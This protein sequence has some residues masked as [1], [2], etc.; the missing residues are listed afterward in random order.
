M[1]K[2]A[3]RAAEIMTRIR[4]LFEKNEMKREV[5]NVNEV[6][7]DTVSLIRAEANRRSIRVETELDAQL[8]TISADR[9]QLQQVLINLMLNGLEA[10]NDTGGELV[11]KSQRN[12]GGAPQISVSD[13]GRGLPG[14]EREKIFD[15]FYTTKQQGTGM[16]LA[17]SRSIV[18]SHGGRLWASA[19]SGR[20]ATFYVSL[21][22]AVTET[23]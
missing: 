12:D 17:I 8:P 16:G 2:E 5:L 1:V 7:S 6:I 10:M 20:G 21:P 23:D 22:Q 9:V 13:A 11:I 3:M 19:N 4:S 18:E 14:G 15:A